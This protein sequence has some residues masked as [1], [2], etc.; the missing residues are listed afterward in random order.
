MKPKRHLLSMLFAASVGMATFLWAQT[1]LPAPEVLRSSNQEVQS[2]GKET[3]PDLPTVSSAGLKIHYTF[4]EVSNGIVTDASGNGNHGTVRNEA[5]I[6]SLG[7]YNVLD[8]GN[9]AGYL[10]MGQAAGSILEA[11]GDYTV[12]VYY[13]V[14]KNASLSG[15]GYFLW[16]F[17]ELEA[18]HAT[19][20]PYVAYRL[21]AQRFALSTGGYN[22][23]YGI[24]TGTASAQDIWQHVVYRQQGSTGELYIDGDLVGTH[25]SVPVPENAFQTAPA[26]NWI[27]RAP[28]HGDNYLKN[29]LVYDFRLYDEAVS[30]AEI[31][32]WAAVTEELTH[33]YYY[34]IT[35]DF[36]VLAE[37]IAQYR[38][39]L[40][41]GTIENYPPMAVA[42][43]KDVL[44]R[45]EEMIEK[46]KGSQFLI[47]DWI[48]ILDAAYEKLLATE[49]IDT[50]GTTSPDYNPEKGFRHPGALHTQE[51]FDRVKALLAANDPITVAAYANLVSNAYSQS[52]VQ[53]YPTEI[54]VRGGGSGENYM[55]AARGA[56][57]AYQNALRW[58]ISGDAAHA[59]RAVLILNSWAAICKGIGGDTNQSLASGLYGYQFANAAEI[60][61]DYEGWNS[62]DFKNFQEWMLSVWYPR[63]ID[64]LRRRHDT[65]ASGRPGHYWSNW[66]LC[67]AL[68]LVSIGILCDDVHIYNQG[69]SF[70]KYDQ[71]G[72]FTEERIPPIINDGLTEFAGNLIPAIH[73]DDRGPYGFLGQMQESGRDQGHALMALGLAVDICQI[74]WNQGDD[75]FSF[76]D[77]RMAAGIEYVAA[78]N[79]GIEELPWSEYWYHDVRTA[80]HNSWKMYGNNDGGRGAFRPYWD[81][82]IGH[83]EGI[84]GVEMPFSR[85]MKGLD[86]V[87]NG[88]GNYGQ[89][90]GGFDHLGF[91]SLMCTRPAVNESQAPTPL[92]ATLLYHGSLLHQSELGGLVNG[93]PNTGTSALPSGSRVTLIPE[94]PVG[95]TD[96]GNWK[97]DTGETTKDLQIT[98][99]ESRLYRVSYT[100]EKGIKSTQVYSIAVE[101]DCR[102]DEVVPAITVNGVTVH[103]TVI[104]LV[105]RTAFTLEAWGKAGWGSYLWSNGSTSSAIEVKHISSDRTYTLVY[106]NQGGSESKINF[107]IQ[108]RFMLPSLSVEGGAIQETETV[109]VNPGQ[110]VELIPMIPEGKEEGLW[111]WNTGANTKN[112]L[113]E[114]VQNS[115][116]YSVTYTYEGSDYHLQFQ[117]YVA[118][119]NKQLGDGIYY[120]LDAT[121]GTYLTNDGSSLIPMFREKYEIED[122]AQ[123]WEFTKDGDRYKIVSLLDNRFLNE[124]GT[125]TTNPYYPSWNTYTLNGIENSDFYS[126]QNG[127]SSGLDYWTINADGSLNGKGSSLLKGYPFEIISAN[128]AAIHQVSNRIPLVL[129]PNPAR[130]YIWVEVQGENEGQFTLF[131]V[132]GRILKTIPCK[133][134]E[135]VISIEELPNGVCIGLLEVEGQIQSAKL[136][137]Q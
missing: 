38:A 6:L 82:I 74:G 61:R 85:A 89:T 68:A 20:G 86:P 97:W 69:L 52:N 15:N 102:A 94:L 120:I 59:E 91:S 100:N 9:G 104:T 125:F 24:Q 111:Q 76:M 46:Q 51:D 114:N 134:G 127:G 96:T 81:R 44:I 4:D 77:N 63:C 109:I 128:T 58:K 93:F 45:A 83:Y 11:L 106:T 42:E 14:H 50:S 55:N 7:K 48:E 112:L 5:S 110:S 119:P 18:N 126:I 131:S 25:P 41:A 67:N 65:W 130:D 12:S 54:I 88:G 123:I 84:K 36:T 26:F 101:G 121:R 73:A 23:E 98:T 108:L 62:D 78:Y 39:F 117:V 21:N 118:V 2:M 28:F 122:G 132:E 66:G 72:V 43:F 22:N 95:E 30:E 116:T 32:E 64:F 16:A 135:N 27:G 53:T 34:G 3:P 8:L 129:Y 13:R 1:G 29:T 90:S 115:Q 105:P 75:L 124:Y 17:S 47:G 60:M 113:I 99:D 103:D 33:E 35:G 49:G 40:S 56:A 71:V 133:P 87:D 37:K 136:I 31:A 10:D 19:G 92:R 107:H 137:K 57:M 70:Y 80:I 79:A